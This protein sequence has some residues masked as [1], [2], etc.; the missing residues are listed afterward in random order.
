MTQLHDIWNTLTRLQAQ[1]EPCAV[2]TVVRALSP[3]SGKPGDKAVVTADG[4]IH[5][6]IG[7]GCAQPAVTRTVREVVETGEPRLIRVAP[8]DSGQQGE[9]GIVDF[10]MGCASR[11]TLDLF[12]EPV[13]AAPV[14]SVHGAAPSAR[15]VADLASRVGLDVQVLAPGT[16]ATDFPGALR[17]VDGHTAPQDWPAPRWAV[18]ATQGQGDRPALE[19]ALGSAAAAIALIASRRKA[20]SLLGAMAERGHA[21]ERLARVHSPAGVDI[22]AHTPAEIALAVVAQVVQWRRDG[23]GVP[24]APRAATGASATGSAAGASAAQGCCGGGTS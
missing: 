14:L 4:T 13:L 20:E 15:H 19:A 6:W 1:G 24:A 22:S 5:G 11:G 16:T 23:A 10:N 12:V 9:E 8:K 21:A 17:H 7:G 2:V 18:V 3:T